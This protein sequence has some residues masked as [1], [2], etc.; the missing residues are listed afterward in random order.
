MTL[1]YDQL[2]LICT[3]LNAYISDYEGVEDDLTI[4]RARALRDAIAKYLNE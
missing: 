2:Y 3:A 1:S 4:D